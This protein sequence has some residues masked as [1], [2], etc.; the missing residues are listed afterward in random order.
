MPPP[1]KKNK[2]NSNNNKKTTTATKKRWIMSSVLTRQKE[3]FSLF[4]FVIL[5]NFNKLLSYLLHCMLIRLGWPFD[6]I[7]DYEL[8]KFGSSIYLGNAGN[9]D[10]KNWFQL[11]Y[12]YLIFWR[13]YLRILRNA[14]SAMYLPGSRLKLSF[15]NDRYNIHREFLKALPMKQIKTWSTNFHCR[16]IDI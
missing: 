8:N 11:I 10:L 2:R 6:G 3:H 16:H 1:K 12:R 5:Y 7:W 9:Y 4:H 15:E 14:N 13:L